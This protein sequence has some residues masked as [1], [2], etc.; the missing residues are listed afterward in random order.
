MKLNKYLTYIQNMILK[1]LEYRGSYRN[2]RQ[3]QKTKATLNI[4]SLMRCFK[5]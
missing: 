4:L 5:K 2:E 1:Y 3:L